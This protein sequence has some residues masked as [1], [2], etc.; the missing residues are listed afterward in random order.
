MTCRAVE[1]EVKND[2]ADVD[3]RRGKK[4][5]PSVYLSCIIRQKLVK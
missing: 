2:L 4:Y 1:K 3:H 5:S